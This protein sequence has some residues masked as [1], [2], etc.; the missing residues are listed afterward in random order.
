M[1]PYKVVSLPTLVVKIGT[2][3]ANKSLVDG[4]W[5]LVCQNDYLNKRIHIVPYK[6][7]PP[8]TLVVKIG[9]KIAINDGWID[10]R[11]QGI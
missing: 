7:V 11:F 8:P 1:V 9:T 2:K 5:S 10:F 4:I 6:V 3:I